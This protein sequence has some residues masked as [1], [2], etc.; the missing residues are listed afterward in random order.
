MKDAEHILE[1]RLKIAELENEILRLKLHR[2]QEKKAPKI[3]F[4]PTTYP[5]TY[6]TTDPWVDTGPRWICIPG[7]QSSTV[8]KS[9]SER[10]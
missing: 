10:F 1:L 5:T 2:E 6:P 9:G 3:D 8:T 7:L 4:T